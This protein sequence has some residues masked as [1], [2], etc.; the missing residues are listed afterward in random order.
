M[1]TMENRLESMEMWIL[2][3]ML[4]ISWTDRI[5]NRRVLE[6]A[7]VHR[8]L[9]GTVKRR[10]LQFLGHIVRAE[11]VENLI[12]TG[13]IEGKRSRGRQR[14]SY[15]NNVKRW[16]GAQTTATEI[17]HRAKDRISW[18]AMIIHIQGHYT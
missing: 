16:L 17:L 6:L 11:E 9:L 14:Y 3:R 8:E 2:R 12:L 15:M 1:K 4:R 5:S 13:K 10:Q 18:R 7:G